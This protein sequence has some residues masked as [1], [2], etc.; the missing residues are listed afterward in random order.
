MGGQ[1]AASVL[2]TRA[3]AARHDATGAGPS[4]RGRVDGGPVGRPEEGGRRVRRLVTDG[5]AWITGQVVHSE[6]GFRRWVR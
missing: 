5:A 2:L 3:F 6:G 4:G 1:R